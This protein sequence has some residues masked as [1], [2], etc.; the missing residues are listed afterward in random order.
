MVRLVTLYLYFVKILSVPLR[1][2]VNVLS[3]TPSYPSI[4]NYQTKSVGLATIFF[5]RNVYSNGLNRVIKVIAHSVAIPLTIE[6]EK[7]EYF[8]AYLPCLS[9]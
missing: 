8:K 3:A 6:G 1:G 4:E 2:K 9:T 5:T 7:K